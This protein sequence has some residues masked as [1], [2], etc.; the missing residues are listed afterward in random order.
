MKKT[1][2]YALM[3]ILMAS[4]AAYAAENEV[5]AIRLATGKSDATNSQMFKSVNKACPNVGV[6]EVTEGTTGGADN[7]GLIMANK[8]DA[9]IAQ[10]D[11]VNFLQRT[12]PNIG[13][14]RSLVALNNNLLHVIATNQ[15]RMIKPAVKGTLGMGAKPAEYAQVNT[16]MDLKGTTVVAN[17]SAWLTMRTI[18]EKLDLGITVIDEDNRDTALKMLRDGTASALIAMGGNPVSWVEKLSGNEFHLVKFG[19]EEAQSRQMIAMLG[20]PYTVAQ[21][22]YKNL[23][24]FGYF[25][26]AVRNELFV[27]NYQGSKA[28]ILMALRECY[29]D[30]L[31]DIKETTGTHP[32]WQ[33]VEDVNV[34]AWPRFEAG[35]TKAPV[36]Q[37]EAQK[38]KGGKRNLSL[39]N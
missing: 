33:D 32:A 7:I 11:V 35:R 15:G 23:N 27:R 21:E 26:P 16:I 3:G 8:V 38:S 37:E 12:D 6:Q 25:V 9:G 36:A 34:T 29:S 28:Q 17:G 1:F 5:Q 2:A 31:T 30:N 4:S 24:A 20:S 13:K 19:K 22:T 18:S 39:A 14:L 10:V